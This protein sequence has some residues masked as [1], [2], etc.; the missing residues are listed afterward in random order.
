MAF[1]V[2]PPKAWFEKPESGIPTDKRITITA[3]GQA[4]GYIALWDTCHVGHPNCVKPPKG[5][6]SAYEYAHQGETLTAEGELIATAVIA[7]GAGHAPMDMATAAVPAYYENTGFQLMRVRYGEDENGLWFAG[8]LWPDV[9]ELQVA[10][11]RASSIS[12]DWRWHA[13][14]RRGQSGHDF[15]GACLVNIPGFPMQKPNDPVNSEAGRPFA[16]AASATT[17]HF[18]DEEEPCMC[19]K[20]CGCEDETPDAVDGA[21]LAA[22]AKHFGLKPITADAAVD[23]E[24]DTQPSEVEQLREQVASLTATVDSLVADKLLA[25]IDND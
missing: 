8:A 20:D 22:I 3:D 5:S 17:H 6:P 19:K 13:A 4:Y 25:E 21:L 18:I 7:G 10:H 23:E 1:P 2:N 9:N 12:G 24:V 11:L 14:W 16:L 15:A